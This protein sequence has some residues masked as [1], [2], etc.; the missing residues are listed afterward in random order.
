MLF[1]KNS[2]ITIFHAKIIHLLAKTSTGHHSERSLQQEVK[3]SLTKTVRSGLLIVCFFFWLEFAFAFL[4]TLEKR[5]VT[6]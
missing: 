1:G 5:N 4:V 3:N 2:I 6:I